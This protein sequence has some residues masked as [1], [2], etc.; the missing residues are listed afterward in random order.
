MDGDHVAGGNSTAAA[1]LVNAIPWVCGAEPG[2]VGGADVPPAV[3][4]GRV[5]VAQKSP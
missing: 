3:G 5:P 1:R 2:L 4:L